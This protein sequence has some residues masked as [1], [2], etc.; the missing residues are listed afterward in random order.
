[1]INLVLS[2]SNALTLPVT[3]WPS[4][5]AVSLGT[6]PFGKYPLKPLTLTLN[7]SGKI[8]TIVPV[9]L[10]PIWKL[11]SAQGLATSC[12]NDKM[13]RFLFKSSSIT[14]ASTSDP[15]ETRSSI[16]ASFSHET[17]LF[18]KNPCTCS[19]KSTTTP[20]LLISLA[21]PLTVAP[22]SVA[23]MKSFQ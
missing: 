23:S 8:L 6:L 7:P 22:T 20:A 10:A 3:S 15:F 16:L 2:G 14:L 18:G 21:I 19:V 5:N 11:A 12:F 13:I 9:T 1:M 17:S 4:S